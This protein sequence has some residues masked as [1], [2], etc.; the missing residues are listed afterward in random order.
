MLWVVF[1]FQAEDGIRDVA[2]T[3]VQT[4]AL[5]ISEMTR[6]SPAIAAARGSHATSRAGAA[7]EHP[8]FGDGCMALTS[9]DY[10]SGHVWTPGNLRIKC[11][12]YCV[13]NNPAEAGLPV[14]KAPVSDRIAKLPNAS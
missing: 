2:V 4:C 6:Y 12:R 11:I 14:S 5:P 7:L 8:N 10:Y 9:H 3:G 1:F 13:C